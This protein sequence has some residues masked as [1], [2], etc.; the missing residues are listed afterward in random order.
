M[1]IIIMHCTT[2][3]LIPYDG[4]PV[5]QIDTVPI[6]LVVIIFLLAAAGIIFTII[7]LIFNI[8]FSKKR[9][10]FHVN[11][12]C[13]IQPPL[14][15][16]SPQNHSDKLSQIKL[17]HN[18]RSSSILQQHNTIHHSHHQCMSM[19]YWPW[20]KLDLGSSR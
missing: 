6:P 18:P 15:P 19:L 17:P 4:M 10:V 5:V 7:C 14:A 13:F 8:V 11:S 1:Q 9:H 20:S 16:H 2:D 3:G 12:A